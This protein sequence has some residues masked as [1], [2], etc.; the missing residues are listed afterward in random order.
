MTRWRPLAC[1]AD[2]FEVVD[3]GE[4]HSPVTTWSVKRLVCGDLDAART[5]VRI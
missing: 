1:G 5:A 2:T 4:V 3:L